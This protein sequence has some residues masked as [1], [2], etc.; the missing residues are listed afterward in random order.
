MG[1]EA[2]AGNDLAAVSYPPKRL[3]LRCADGKQVHSF[4]QDP[5]PVK[6]ASIRGDVEGYRRENCE[7]A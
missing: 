2:D 4:H 6:K 5:L 1:G 7:Q 3:Q